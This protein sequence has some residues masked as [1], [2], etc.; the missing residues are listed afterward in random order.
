MKEKEELEQELARLTELKVKRREEIKDK[1]KKEVEQTRKRNRELK[2]Q[3][4][5]LT[6]SRLVQSGVHTSRLRFLIRPSPF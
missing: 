5:A 2:A 6:H 3:V 1:L 4:E